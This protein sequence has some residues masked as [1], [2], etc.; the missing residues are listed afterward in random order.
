MINHTPIILSSKVTIGEA[1]AQITEVTNNSQR[2]AVVIDQD[3]TGSQ[4]ILG[5]LTET[6]ILK[7]I[8]TV[9]NWQNQAI[10]SITP[11]HKL[12]VNHIPP[13]PIDILNL[14]QAEQV[15]HLIVIDSEKYPVGVI[16]E[17]DLLKHILANAPEG[18]HQINQKIIAIEKQNFKLEA[19]ISDRTKARN[20]W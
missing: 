17:A 8:A 20:I 18:M 11:T 13:D 16:S 7:A 3:F 2:Y 10:A 19:Q 6:V 5:I 4:S 14:L 9:T 12:I 1:I 15:S